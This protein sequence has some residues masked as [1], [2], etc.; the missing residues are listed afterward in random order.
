[1][2]SGNAVGTSNCN[3]TTTAVRGVQQNALVASAS[4]TA[5]GQSQASVNA[6][7]SSFNSVSEVGITVPGSESNQ[8]FGTVSAFA[9]EDEEHVIILRLLGKTESGKDV[10]A[11]ITVKTKARCVT[12]GRNNKATAHFCVDCGTSLSIL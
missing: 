4:L 9:T 6:V 1:M 2:W 11:P 5:S 8:K 3:V 7:H 12:C 10:T